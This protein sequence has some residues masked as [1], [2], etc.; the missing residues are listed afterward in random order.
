M[1]SVKELYVM[2]KSVRNFHQGQRY[3]RCLYIALGEYHY[4][5]LE[6]LHKI[7]IENINSVGYKEYSERCLALNEINLYEE[8]L[9]HYDFIEKRKFRLA[10]VSNEYEYVRFFKSLGVNLYYIVNYLDSRRSL[11]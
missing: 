2:K 7:V 11:L 5:K 4:K 9:K 8:F 3:K 10:I 6:K 1:R